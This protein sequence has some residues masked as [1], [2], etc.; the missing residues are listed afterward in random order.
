MIRSLFI[1]LLSLS[2]IISG[3][4]SLALGDFDGEV[5]GFWWLVDSEDLLISQITS[6]GFSAELSEITE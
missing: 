4:K 1:P 3:P 2:L 6:L 5:G